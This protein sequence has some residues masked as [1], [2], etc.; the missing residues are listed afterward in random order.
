MSKYIIILLSVCLIAC[1]DEN[2]LTAD[3]LQDEMSDIY[4]QMVSLTN[5]SCTNNDSC[6]AAAYGV[7]PCGGPADYIIYA[8]IADEGRFEELRG[9]YNALNAKYN[10]LTGAISNCAIENPPAMECISGDC[11]EV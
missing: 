4:A 2:D 1:S 11:Q 5:L 6:K 8:S 10:E 3:E 9:R 7:K